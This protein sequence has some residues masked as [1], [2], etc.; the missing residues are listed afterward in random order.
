M[1]ESEAMKELIDRYDCEI[2]L[3]GWGVR[4]YHRNIS[5]IIRFIENEQKWGNGN[6][7]IGSKQ[8]WST[9]EFAERRRLTTNEL[10]N[11]FDRYL[12][13]RP[14]PSEEQMSLF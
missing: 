10:F 8:D 3:S 7:W 12:P 2:Y 1:T 5:I 9:G 4:C 14:E 13:R 6:L 11:V